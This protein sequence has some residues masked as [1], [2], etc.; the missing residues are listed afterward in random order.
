MNEIPKFAAP[1]T[2][3]TGP[4]TGSRKVYASP[5]GRVDIRVPFREITLSDPNEA[6]VRVYDPS[7]PYTES[8]IAIDLASKFWSL[9]KGHAP[10]NHRS[11][12][13]K[14]ECG[15]KVR[16]KKHP[17]LLNRFSTINESIH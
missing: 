16:S 17:K 6:P 14:R 9:R 4:I 7:G 5:S 10:S 11:E 2:V 1:Q 13:G 15:T 3:T 12:E 8:H